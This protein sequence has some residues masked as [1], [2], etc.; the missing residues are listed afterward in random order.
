MKLYRTDY[1][2]AARYVK[3]ACELLERGSFAKTIKIREV[4]QQLARRLCS[5]DTYVGS[6]ATEVTVPRQAAERVSMADA[7]V[8][9]LK[10][11]AVLA[12][13]VYRSFKEPSVF[14][15]HGLS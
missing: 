9:I 12:D 11:V 10:A 5:G 6:D 13:R 1:D 15:E 4:L 7:R 3:Y 2:Q 14:S 8:E